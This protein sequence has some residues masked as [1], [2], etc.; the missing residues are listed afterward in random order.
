[1]CFI[2][3]HNSQDPATTAEQAS[4]FFPGLPRHSICALFQLSFLRLGELDPPNDRPKTADLL[5]GTD[6]DKSDYH[7]SKCHITFSIS[8]SHRG[9]WKRWEERIQRTGCSKK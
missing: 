9:T 7:Q 4:W 3:H 2:Y 6:D 5:S 8:L 1:M